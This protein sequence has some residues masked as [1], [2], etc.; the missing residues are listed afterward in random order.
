MDKIKVL[1]TASFLLLGLFVGW[2]FGFH[3]GKHDQLSRPEEF[4]EGG[5]I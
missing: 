2:V 5:G 3:A 4:D 1:V